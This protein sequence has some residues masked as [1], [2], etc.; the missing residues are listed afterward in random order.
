MDF[1]FLYYSMLCCNAM[2]GERLWPDV[3]SPLAR[4]ILAGAFDAVPFKESLSRKL[5][6][7]SLPSEAIVEYREDLKRRLRKSG[8]AQAMVAGQDLLPNIY[9][10]LPQPLRAWEKLWKPRSFRA[11]AHHIVRYMDWY[12]E[13][14][15]HVSSD[16]TKPRLRVL[17]LGAAAVAVLVY[18]SLLGLIRSDMLASEV[19]L[20]AFTVLVVLF[21]A[22]Y[23]NSGRHRAA[24]LEMNAVR[25]AEFLFY[26]IDSYSDAPSDSDDKATNIFSD[27]PAADAISELKLKHIMDALPPSM[28]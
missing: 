9:E 17:F 26:L 28:E 27:M 5:D 18:S 21:A 22:N 11:L 2:D 10:V 1:A 24:L 23:L 15:P 25:V 14:Q 16:L 8:L 4:Q 19:F 6:Y 7:L 13:P 3:T 20:S 12:V